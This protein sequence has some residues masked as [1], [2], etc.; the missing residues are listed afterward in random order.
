MQK[1]KNKIKEVDEAVSI[2]KNFISD[3]EL[4]S[5]LETREIKYKLDRNEWI[6]E[7]RA[8][9]EINAKIE[10]VCKL[11]MKYGIDIDTAMKDFELDA[12]YKPQVLKKLKN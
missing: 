11:I 1:L 10:D 9:G 12:E 8:E 3:E 2:Y 7:G 6:A 5:I 4:K